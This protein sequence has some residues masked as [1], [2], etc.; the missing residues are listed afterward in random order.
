[1]VKAFFPGGLGAGKV[2]LQFVCPQDRRPTDA[3]IVS[4][5]RL[6]FSHEQ[7]RWNPDDDPDLAAWQDSRVIHFCRNDLLRR[8][9]QFSL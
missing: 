8:I 6:V 5:W 2:E 9:D 7:L 3:E 1:M 4:F